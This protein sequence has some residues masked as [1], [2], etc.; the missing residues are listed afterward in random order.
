MRSC[1]PL[2]RLTALREKRVF[3]T[4]EA[5]EICRIGLQNYFAGAL[6][7]PYESFLKRARELRHD[8]DLLSAQ[9]GA[10]LEQICHV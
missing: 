5:V 8:L 3:R 9:F 6:L 4:A 7:L 1:L 10:S 2:N